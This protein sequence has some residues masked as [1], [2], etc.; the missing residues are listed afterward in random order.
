M[1][2]VSAVLVELQITSGCGQ[3]GF[4]VS[5]LY[6]KCR[7]YNLNFLPENCKMVGCGLFVQIQP[8]ALCF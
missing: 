3:G 4:S 1:F 8:G 6:H 2:S 7:P 5:K